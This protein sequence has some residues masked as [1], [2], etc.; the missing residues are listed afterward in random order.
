M[1]LRE[2]LTRN[3]LK[4]NRGQ[5]S[6]IGELLSKKYRDSGGELYTEFSP[7]IGANVNTYP[8]VFLDS[9]ADLIIQFLTEKA[10]ANG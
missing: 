4:L 5:E 6:R 8:V 7:E 3:G 1:T 9:S 10:Y 2:Y